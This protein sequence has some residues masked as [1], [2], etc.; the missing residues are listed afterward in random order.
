MNLRRNVSAAAC[1][2]FSAAQAAN[3]AARHVVEVSVP[4]RLKMERTAGDLLVSY[5]PASLRKVKITVG[6]KM[7]V[8]IRDE[9]RVYGPGEGAAVAT[10]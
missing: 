1:L 2:L 7:A 8:G 9:L 3:P 10:A 6:E 4:G 5:D